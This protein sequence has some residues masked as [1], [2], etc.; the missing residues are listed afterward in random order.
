MIGPRP[1]EAFSR[2]AATRPFRSR[3]GGRNAARLRFLS[4]GLALLLLSFGAGSLLAQE[5]PAPS[6]PLPEH[7]AV[8]QARIEETARA[9]ATDP[10]FKKVPPDARMARVEFVVGNLLFVTTHEMGHAA[11]AEFNLPVLG[12]EE[13]AADDF[14]II[15]A[16]RVLA[17]DF[18]YRVLDVA[19]EGWFLMATRDKH[20]GDMPAYYDRHGL[21]EQRA[22]QIVCM[23]VGADPIR[24]KALADRTKLPDDRR[25][26]CGWDYET[27]S[28]SWRVLEPYLRQPQ[29]PR[30]PIEVVYG[31]AK[32]KLAVF[33]KSFR[34]MRF[35]ETLAD[36]FGDRYRWPAPITMEMRSCDEPGARWTNRTRRLSICYELAQDLAELY[37]RF[38]R[39]MT[40]GRRMPKAGRG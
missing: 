17:N 22:Y 26:S 9:L 13:D 12:R 4:S 23:M 27:A 3:G 21:D 8:F 36:Y 16:L 35:L 37:R 40:M 38:G 25:K 34:D 14:A 15:T 28:R 18:S 32:G 31:D 33:A 7:F 1:V 19:A 30:T 11:I 2:N 24:F 39:A 10:T 20:D 6:A 29:D 5:A